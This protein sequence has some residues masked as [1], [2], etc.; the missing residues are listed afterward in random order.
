MSFLF[1]NNCVSIYLAYYIQRPFAFLCPLYYYWELLSIIN[2]L[3][4]SQWLHLNL[5][6]KSCLLWYPWNCTA[7][8]QKKHL[9]HSQYDL[10]FLPHI[11][12]LFF[13]MCFCLLRYCLSL[14]FSH[15]TLVNMSANF[16]HSIILRIRCVKFMVYHLQIELAVKI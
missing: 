1:D 10:S 11:S 7:C 14:S 5:K 16:S 15:K 3:V 4:S 13:F 8:Q 6:K 9:Y 2:L 12:H